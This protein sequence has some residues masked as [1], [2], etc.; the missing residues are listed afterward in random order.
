MKLSNDF[1]KGLLKNFNNLKHDKDFYSFALNISPVENLLD[2]TTKQNENTLKP[3]LSLH[4]SD[5]YIVGEE[6]LG[7]DEYVFFISDKEGTGF[8]Q[9]LLVSN[10]TITVKYDN[11]GLNI[12]PKHPIKSTYRINHKGER[13]IYFVDGYND[14]RVIN[15]DTIELTDLVGSLAINPSYDISNPELSTK[16]ISGGGVLLAG[17]YS[18]LISF[19]DKNKKT[20][21]ERAQANNIPIEQGNYYEDEGLSYTPLSADNIAKYIQISADNSVKGSSGE[22]G[23]TDKSIQ[24][25]I[26][27]LD[28]DLYPTLDIYLVRRTATDVEVLMLED[29]KSSK[30]INISGG[31]DFENLGSELSTVIV[32]TI[33]YN[34]SHAITQYNNRLIRA[35]TYSENANSD[36]QEIANNI[37]VTFRV[38]E[39]KSSIAVSD[40]TPLALDNGSAK[41]SSRIR[42]KMSFMESYN[43][44]PSY[45][46]NSNN[47]DNPDQDKGTFLR[48]EVY[49]LG[50]YF[51]LKD[52]SF[53]DVF[54]IPGRALNTF[55]STAPVL[56]EDE[57][58]LDLNQNRN[59][60][61]SA[62]YTQD[63][64]TKPRWQFVNTATLLGNS[65]NLGY[66][67][68]DTTYPKGYKFPTD[69]EKDSLGDSYIR[70]HRMPSES[71]VPSFRYIKDSYNNYTTLIK[72]NI[73]LDFKLPNIPQ[74]IKENIKNVFYTSARRS[75]FDK[76]VIGNGLSYRM[77]Y[78]EDDS[79]TSIFNSF[80]L[81]KPLSLTDSEFPVEFKLYSNYFQFISPD[82][83]FKFKE[84]SLNGYLIKPNY[85]IRSRTLYLARTTPETGSDFTGLAGRYSNWKVATDTYEESFIA[86][87]SFYGDVRMPDSFKQFKIESIG[88]YD[89]NSKTTFDSRLLDLTGG[90]NTV[91]LKATS[92]SGYFEYSP[93]NFD[94]TSFYDLI[95]VQ[96]SLIGEDRAYY[97]SSML[98]TI[99]TNNTN[100]F[101][102]ILN[103]EYDTLVKDTHNELSE[104]TLVYGDAFIDNHISKRSQALEAS[105]NHPVNGLSTFTSI[106][107]DFVKSTTAQD[108]VLANVIIS[109]NYIKFPVTSRINLRLAQE[110]SETNDYNKILSAENPSDEALN[111]ASKIV[112]YK[113]DR[114]YYSKDSVVPLFARNIKVEDLLTRSRLYNRVVYSEPQNFESEIDSY[115]DTL[116]NNYK[117]IPSNKGQI[118][119]LFIQDNNLYIV[120]R[121]SIFIMFASQSQ[122]QVSSGE[123]ISVGM[124]DFLSG[125]IQ[126]L[127]TT[128]GG[129][130]GSSSK[131]GLLETPHG[132]FIVDILRDKIFRLSSQEGLEDI[133]TF[134]I[135][136]QF[137]VSALNF[138][139]EEGFDNPLLEKGVTVGYDPR[140]QRVLITFNNK[141][142]SVNKSFTASFDPLL[143]SWISYHD[144]FPRRYI[145]ATKELI[146]N[147]KDLD[148]FNTEEYKGNFI[149]ETVFNE[150]AKDNKVFDSL[151]FE[152]SS[153]NT[154][155]E[156]TRDF[157]DKLIAY[158]DTQSTGEVKLNFGTNYTFKEFPN[159][160]NFNQLLD[161]SKDVVPIKLFK[162]DWD[163]IKDVYPIDK[164]V[165]NNSLDL[166]KPWYNRG[167]L[168][169]TY[170]KVRVFGIPSKKSKIILNYI[171]ANIRPSIR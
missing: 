46:A 79:S 163:S 167:R 117:D 144:Y 107:N 59:T 45:L 101:S 63:G 57:T 3:Y 44:D 87:H 77:S 151:E 36:F 1:S 134:G 72:S 78:R 92:D 128:E 161:I 6:W 139:D 5:Y 165:D 168:R 18:V 61:D 104:R 55:P 123:Q 169:S 170:L 33:N 171:N 113:I 86:N 12:S 89:G 64:E 137:G 155:G 35:N 48:D 21:L 29:F 90:Q 82:T 27:G 37:E 62:N 22:S 95:G 166:N 15:I 31:E 135:Q 83:D 26:L 53:T 157:F 108:L 130:G 129:Y 152:V 73:I 106:I 121:D 69:G 24:I 47:K 115:R 98:C 109:N 146:L 159:K 30:L 43:L 145:Q 158:N 81:S 13:I 103:L 14:D 141:E 34:K 85:L 119:N 19:K 150:A 148:K 105:F 25:E 96:G 67:R 147:I 28:L 102:N 9:I 76:K 51:E 160:Y 54:H 97:D 112:D 41:I 122:L 8:N 10:N 74:N 100:I 99:L 111:Y 156:I 149:I 23:R 94:L 32:N 38:Q 68:T 110:D 42:N 65:G 84:S 133:N 154:T 66:Y 20:S 56:G 16:V 11:L 162:D 126:E 50:V 39:V 116:A 125:G 164:V 4:T 153:E 93:S 60:F 120:T 140:L 118:S 114:V 142:G 17:E 127:M 80:D 70:H 71:L 88:F 124:G 136:E 58:G 7:K 52:G 131:E 138:L 40:I 132:V 2:R 91:I 143:K 49:A 75:E